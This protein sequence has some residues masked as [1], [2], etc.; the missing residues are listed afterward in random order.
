MTECPELAGKVIKLLTVY[1]DACDGPQ[2]VI[3]FTDGSVFSASL[4]TKSY[5]E[6]KHSRDDGGRPI[7]LKDYSST[8]ISR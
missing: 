8:T 4:V 1:E 6:A 3:E 2:V 7:V 5:I